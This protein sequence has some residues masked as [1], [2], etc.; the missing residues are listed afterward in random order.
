MYIR[1]TSYAVTETPNERYNSTQREPLN[2]KEAVAFAAVIDNV[3]P[4][5]PGSAALESRN[6]P[7]TET[8]A[9]D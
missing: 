4:V 7:V 2:I 5:V 3:A 9:L 8:A 1:S 6:E